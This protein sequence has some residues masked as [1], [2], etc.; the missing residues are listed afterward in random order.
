MKNAGPETAV[1]SCQKPDL[2]YYTPKKVDGYEQ[3]T[4]IT[5]WSFTCKDVKEEVS[6]DETGEII[7]AKWIFA[8]LYTMVATVIYLL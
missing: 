5:D 4:A 8:S 1:H 6:E 2:A 3:Y 7:G